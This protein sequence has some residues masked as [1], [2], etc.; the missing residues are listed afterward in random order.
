VSRRCPEALALHKNAFMNALLSNEATLRPSPIFDTNVFGDVQREGISKADWNYALRR[1]PGH[2]WSLSNVT[3]LEL[4]VAVD[5]APHVGCF[6][7]P[8]HS[9]NPRKLFSLL[10]GWQGPWLLTEANSLMVRHVAD[11]YNFSSQPAATAAATGRKNDELVL[12]R[13]RSLQ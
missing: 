3:A 12:W 2:G 9:P 1:R 10:A 4:L 8:P 6:A 5:A 11:C 13:K 7:D